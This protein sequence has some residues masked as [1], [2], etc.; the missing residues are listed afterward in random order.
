MGALARDDLYASARPLSSPS[1]AH[2]SSPPSVGAWK[3]R[4]LALVIGSD[5]G[6]R[7][8]QEQLPWS[9]STGAIGKLALSG[10]LSGQLSSQLAT[11]AATASDGH[12]E[13]TGEWMT[14][15][16]SDDECG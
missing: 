13:W 7:A 4:L 6:S 10:Q 14:S 15:K 3:R 12:R 16:M 11:A 1:L 5:R 9:S 8:I 2:T